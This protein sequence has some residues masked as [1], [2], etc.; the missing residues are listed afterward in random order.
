MDELMG[1][2]GPAYIWLKAVHVI[3][4]LYW[5]AGLLLLPRYLAYQAEEAPGSPEDAKWH[6]RIARL[7]KIILTPGLI[8]VWLTGL[9]L[10][11][12]YGLKGAGWLHT[13]ITLVL[14]LSAYHGWAIATAKKMARGERPRASRTLR[15]LNEVPALLVIPIVI[16][17]ITKLF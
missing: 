16:L 12:S 13:K 11:V 7:R 9:A 14:I 3:F 4:V 8:L 15:L 5:V 10:A 17:V 1:W 6:P 2:L